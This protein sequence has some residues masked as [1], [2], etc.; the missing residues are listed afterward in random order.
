M[1]QYEDFHI[2]IT[3]IKTNNVNPPRRGFLSWPKWFR[4]EDF[5]I[6]TCFISRAKNTLLNMFAL[7]DLNAYLVWHKMNNTPWNNKKLT[8]PPLIIR[9]T[10]N[11]VN[12]KCTTIN[13]TNMMGYRKFVLSSLSVKKVPSR[14]YNSACTFPLNF[15]AQFVFQNDKF[16]LTQMTKIVISI[17]WSRLTSV[18]TN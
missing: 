14:R 5:G 1:V 15:D 13:P 2:H 8:L 9:K 10:K 16:V 17:K 3:Y 18:L 4:E 11:S 12:S 6:H 7:E